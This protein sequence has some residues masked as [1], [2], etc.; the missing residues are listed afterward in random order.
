R[1]TPNEIALQA[2]LTALKEE[3]RDVSRPWLIAMQARLLLSSQEENERRAGEQLLR[4]LAD[5]YSSELLG[6]ALRGVPPEYQQ[7]LFE[8]VVAPILFEDRN[9]LYEIFQEWILVDTAQV[10]RKLIARYQ[11]MPHLQA[12]LAVWLLYYDSSEGIESLRKAVQS[13]EDSSSLWRLYDHLPLNEEFF[14]EKGWPGIRGDLLQKAVAVFR[15]D[16]SGL[17]RFADAVGR[18]DAELAS[19]L[20]AK[21]QELQAQQGGG[22]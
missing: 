20:R 16:W 10:Y 4:V 8:E 7:R 12:V 5:S 11:G 13:V 21:A 14:K 6:D 15:N 17:S 1:A 9:F 3:Y 2:L 22:S 19:D 18:H